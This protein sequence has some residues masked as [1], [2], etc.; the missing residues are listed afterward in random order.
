M[1]YRKKPLVVEA[2]QWTGENWDEIEM[3]SGETSVRRAPDSPTMGIL[4]LEGWMAANPGDWIIRGV[5]G[6]FYPCKNG[7]F[8]ASYDLVE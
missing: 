1:K 4:T 5:C 7:I 3:F 6:E 2:V 8:S